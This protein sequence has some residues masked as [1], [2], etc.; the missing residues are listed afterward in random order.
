MAPC[1]S[2]AVR[3]PVRSDESIADPSPHPH[4]ESGARIAAALREEIL[5]GAY[6]PGERI[7]QQ[8]LAGI[9]SASRLPVR[10]ALRMLESEGL[11]TIIA[12]AGS[13]VS[14]LSP[15]ECAEMYQIRE[16]L[17]PL[18]LEY[19]AGS[20]SGDV[21]ERLQHLADAMQDSADVEDFLRLDREFH[22]LCYSGTATILLGETIVQ[23]WNRTQHYR[24]VFVRMFRAEGDGSVHHEHQLLVAALRDGD[25]ASAEQVLAGHIRRTRLALARHPEI[26]ES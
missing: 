1:P 16:R 20:L 25:S 11:V 18:L 2:T 24:R 14:Q 9:H 15:E 10:D 17:E 6:R 19:S 5:G 3:E 22:L 8:E 12:N 4:G 26:F 23:L 21:I 7:R 13:W